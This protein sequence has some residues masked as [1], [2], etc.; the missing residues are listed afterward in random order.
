MPI[1]LYSDVKI[2]G[3]GTYIVPD[4]IPI[5]A[6]QLYKHPE[7]L[8]P[9]MTT[10]EQQGVPKRPYD[11]GFYVNAINTV[12]KEAFVNA[13]GKAGDIYLLHPLM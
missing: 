9:D 7:G 3:G 6:K 1:V 8:R 2:G 12:P 13:T 10:R 5:L 4:A 11:H